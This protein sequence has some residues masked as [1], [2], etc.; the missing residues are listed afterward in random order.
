MYF[1]SNGVKIKKTNQTKNP[2]KKTLVQ[3]QQNKCIE[4]MNIKSSNI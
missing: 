1:A 3:S 2:P 4:F